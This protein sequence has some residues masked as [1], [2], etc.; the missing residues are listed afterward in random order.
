MTS[1]SIGTYSIDIDVVGERT[2]KR[3]SDLT[4]IHILL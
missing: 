3:T 4:G 2:E 1:E